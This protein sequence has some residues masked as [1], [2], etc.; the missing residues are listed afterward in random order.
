MTA[1][2][3]TIALITLAFAGAAAA[4]DAPATSAATSAAQAAVAAQSVAAAPAAAPAPATKRDQAKAEAI[5][6]MNNRR[7]TEASQFD[8]FMK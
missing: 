3:L 4:A 8:W 2:K 7:A 6:A 5:E 1:P